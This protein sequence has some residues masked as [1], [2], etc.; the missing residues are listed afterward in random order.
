MN[1]WKNFKG[2]IGTQ[3]SGDEIHLGVHLF[4]NQPSS[5]KRK[6]TKSDMTN[7]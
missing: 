1:N 6:H 7:N 4:F 5:K 3:K 2:P